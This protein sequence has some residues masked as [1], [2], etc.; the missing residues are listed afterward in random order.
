[1][2]FGWKVK[3]VNRLKVDEKQSQSGRK[4]DEIHAEIFEKTTSNWR[5]VFKRKKNWS[6]GKQ[7]EQ[8]ALSE[9]IYYI[10]FGCRTKIYVAAHKI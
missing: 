4:N 2:L 8:F 3:I 9:Y 6:S 10:S 5:R 1:M 7:S